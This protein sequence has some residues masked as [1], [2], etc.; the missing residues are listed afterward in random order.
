MAE[1]NVSHAPSSNTRQYLIPKEIMSALSAIGQTKGKSHAIKHFVGG[2]IAGAYVSF[3]GMYAIS[4]A[5]GIDPTVRGDNPAISKLLIGV[6]FWTAL[7]LIVC[8]GGELFTGNLMYLL[9]ARIERRVTTLQM[10]RNWVVVF[11][12][13]FLGCA[14]LAYFLGYLTDFYAK[15][16]YLSFVKSVAESKVAKSFGVLFLRGVG[17][18]WM[19]C[20]A[21]CFAVASQDQISRIVS[22]FLPIGLFAV[23]GFEHCVANMFYGPLGM[24]YG[25]EVDF[26]EFLYKNIIP[27]ALGNFVGGALLCGVGLWF[28]HIYQL[29]GEGGRPHRASL[30]EE[31]TEET[32]KK[33]SL[34]E[35]KDLK[36][37]KS[38][39]LARRP[40]RLFTHLNTFMN[41]PTS[42]DSA[43]VG[44]KDMRI[45][46]PLLDRLSHILE[47]MDME[48][49]GKP[50]PGAF[51]FGKYSK[52]LDVA[53]SE[54]DG[55]PVVYFAKR[56]MRKNGE[57]MKMR[58]AAA[59]ITEEQA[60]ELSGL[61]YEHE[62]VSHGESRVV[63]ITDNEK[64]ASENV[65][66]IPT[67]FSA[68]P[69]PPKTMKRIVS[70]LRLIGGQQKGTVLGEGMV[71]M[72]WD[73]KKKVE[74]CKL[75]SLDRPFA[76]MFGYRATEMVG[77]TLHE[78]T[79]G[80]DN[81][82]STLQLKQGLKKAKS[83]LRRISEAVLQ[84]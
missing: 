37:S 5:G 6:T 67:A 13:N 78:L 8:C 72:Q 58:V 41:V 18:N 11:V 65:T 56:Y 70:R 69:G 29:P 39:E 21:V 19:V 4:A 53:L 62:A 83:R 47:D 54:S 36:M 51:R 24:F 73:G 81:S 17:A 1:C 33:G 84:H 75:Y 26:G 32:E 71:S 25:A 3:G 68:T 46:D 44:S 76:A 27:V 43:Q 2:L 20:C 7:I 59:I 64:E 9:L 49:G 12:G 55:F 30:D 10:V 42:P 38:S 28:L 77:M 22:C 50:P 52:N 45:K 15:E 60:E 31:E 14:C 74:E 34:E 48:D 61:A 35:L 40:S 23:V 66:D 16:P 82:V 79:Y 63:S 57:V 80:E